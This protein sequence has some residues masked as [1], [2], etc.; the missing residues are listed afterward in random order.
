MSGLSTEQLWFV[1]IIF[2]ESQYQCEL[3]DVSLEAEHA[4]S[5]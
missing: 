2:L 3:C 5:V 1:L 4:R